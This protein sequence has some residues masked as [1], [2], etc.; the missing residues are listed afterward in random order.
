M[1]ENLVFRCE[2]SGA[3]SGLTRRKTF[4]SPN[5]M[6]VEG[7][8]LG[9]DCR[10]ESMTCKGRGDKS[11]TRPFGLRNGPKEADRILRENYMISH[12]RRA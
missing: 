4:F 10:Y 8:L 7:V 3:G 11:L 1:K 12:G 5:Q 9:P 6:V 2:G